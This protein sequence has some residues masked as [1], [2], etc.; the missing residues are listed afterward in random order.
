MYEQRKEV[1]MAERN[2]SLLILLMN[3]IIS[4]LK[5]YNVSFAKLAFEHYDPKSFVLCKQFW[6]LF[7]T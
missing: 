2:L 4:R 3:L 5:T 1:I 6:P 7:V